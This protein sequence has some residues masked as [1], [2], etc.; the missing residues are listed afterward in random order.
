MHR[1]LWRYLRASLPAL[2]LVYAISA[3]AW[4]YGVIVGKYRVFP[5]RLLDEAH[6]GA[7]YL[8]AHWEGMLGRKPTFILKPTRN[9]GDGVTRLRRDGMQPG[10]TFVAGFRDEM[11]GMWLMSPDGEVVHRWIASVTAIWPDGD[12]VPKYARADWATGVCGSVVLPDMSVVLS[13]SNAGMAKLDRSGAVVWALPHTTHH[14]VSQAEDGT[15]WTAGRIEWPER[16]PELPMMAPPFEEDTV[17]QISADG[18]VLREIS[19]LRLLLDADME[20]SLFPVGAQTL[21]GASRDLTHLNDVEVLRTDMA[22]AFPTLAAGDVMLSLR[23]INLIVVFDPNT[24][25]VKW[26]QT[27]PWHRQH[28]PDFLADGGISVLNN[29]MDDTRTGSIFGGSNIVIVDPGS[30][31]TRTVYAGNDRDPFFTNIQGRHQHLPNGNMLITETDAGRV[32][33]VDAG[34]EIVW[35]FVNSYDEDHVAVVWHAERLPAGYF[36]APR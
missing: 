28:D 26:R 27:G 25:E 36:D 17:V 21:K 22:D 12:T 3:G 33:E 30:R 34:G 14:I 15:F 20:G 2:L 32:F 24:L 9:R 35:E 19:V 10:L 8:V 29:R 11:P 6:D 18:A 4:G 1:K 13:F 5:Y 31:Q 16:N 23:N 7:K